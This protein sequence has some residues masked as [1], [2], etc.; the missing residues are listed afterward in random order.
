MNTVPAHKSINMPVINNPNLPY[1]AYNLQ[2]E[3]SISKDLMQFSK[4]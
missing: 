2:K 3:A 1:S 4:H